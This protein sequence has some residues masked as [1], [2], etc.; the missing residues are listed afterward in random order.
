MLRHGLPDVSVD[1]IA[2][3]AGSSKATIYRWWP[4]KELLALDAV[5]ASWE[6][7]LGG[8]R[9]D[10]GTLRG[11]LRRLLRPW[12]RRLDDRPYARVV[13]ALIA[14]AHRDPEFA[15]VWR[16]RFVTMRRKRAKA[17]FARAVDRGEIAASTD[18]DLA[19]DMVY[20]PL[21]HRLLHGHAPLNERIALQLIDNVLTGILV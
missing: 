11:D 7:D 8:L 19:V 1:E 6:E 9:P 2:K 15:A 17:A 20:G 14:E 3:L 18:V 10:T 12:I 16:E 13:A 4:S 21:Y 5:V